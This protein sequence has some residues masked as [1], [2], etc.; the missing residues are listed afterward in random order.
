MTPP[1]P[2]EQCD[3]RSVGAPFGFLHVGDFAATDGR[4]IVIL[5]QLGHEKEREHH[6]PRELRDATCANLER[7]GWSGKWGLGGVCREMEDAANFALAGY[8]WFTFDLAPRVDESADTASLDELDA[9]IVALEDAGIYPAGW[10]EAYLGGDA[11][12]HEEVLARA[13]VKFGAALTH[14]EDLQQALRTAWSGRGNLP[15]I[16]ISIRRLLRKTTLE[17]TRFIAMELLRRGIWAGVFAPALGPEYQPG[18]HP[19]EA[20]D[21]A[22]FAELLR[23]HGSLRLASLGA[24][25]IDCTDYAFFAMLAYLAGRDAPLFRAI[26]TAAR[27]VFPVVRSGWHILLSDDDVRMM[28]DVDDEALAPTYIEHPHGRQLLLCTWDA[29]CESLGDRIRAAL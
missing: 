8:T 10:H 22:G 15:D 17:E 4:A 21:V 27:D 16:E 11:P 28:P 24:S 1:V 5:H 23:A 29:V 13:A 2:L 3:T 25:H 9:G 20:P 6:G 12:F 7:S 18:L 19:A 26:L 14:A